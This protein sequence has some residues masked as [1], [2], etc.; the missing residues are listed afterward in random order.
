MP[1]NCIECDVRNCV[2]HANNVNYCTLDCIKV[3]HNTVSDSISE[4]CTDCGSFELD[5]SCRECN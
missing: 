2:H 1:N 3:T 4:K 5:G